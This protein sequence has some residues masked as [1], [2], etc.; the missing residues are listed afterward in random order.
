M[1]ENVR[2][3]FLISLISLI[4]LSVQAES[5]VFEMSVFGYTF[6]EMVLTRTVKNDS[7]E[8]YTLNSKGE[9]NIFWMNRKGESSLVVEYRNGKLHSSV[10]EYYNR[11]Q[12]EKWSRTRFDGDK[13]I[14]TTSDGELEFP[15]NPSFSL[16]KLYFEPT[17]TGDS[18]FCEED[19]S[20][21]AVTHDSDKDMFSVKCQDGSRSTYHVKDGRVETMEIHLGIGSVKLKRKS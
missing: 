16:I 20:Y 19:G 14:A 5:I 3:F 18:I 7:I 13:Y 6:G 4:S 10:Y 21:A 11:G 15:E 12:L 8:I 9:T 17:W 1:K 2:R